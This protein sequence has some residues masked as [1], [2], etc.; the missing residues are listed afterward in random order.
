[1]FRRAD[2]EDSDQTALMARLIFGFAGRT[3]H[4]VAFVL[5]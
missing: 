4:F 2:S 1:M 3:C 5:R